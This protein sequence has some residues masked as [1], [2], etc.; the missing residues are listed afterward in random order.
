MIATDIQMLPVYVITAFILLPWLLQKF[1]VTSLE[2][3]SINVQK[4]VGH[5]KYDNFCCC[6]YRLIGNVG[7]AQFGKACYWIAIEASISFSVSSSSLFFNLTYWLPCQ[8]DRYLQ[9]ESKVLIF[10]FLFSCNSVRVWWKYI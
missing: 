6:L 10:F 9:I 3:W 4:A 5:V 1:K 7:L 2:I 8:K